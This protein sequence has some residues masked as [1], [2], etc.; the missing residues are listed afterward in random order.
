MP[1]KNGCT[2]MVGDVIVPPA[3]EVVVSVLMPVTKKSS[4]PTFSTA[5]WLFDA[6]MR[7]VDVRVHGAPL[8]HRGLLRQAQRGG[9]LIGEAARVRLAADVE[10]AGGEQR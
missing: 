8:R 7:C 3:P 10:P 9:D 1:K 6:A 4:V 2:V 5:F